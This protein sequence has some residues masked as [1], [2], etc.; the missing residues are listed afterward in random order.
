[1]GSVAVIVTEK[2]AEEIKKVGHCELRGKVSESATTQNRSDAFTRWFLPA[3][4]CGATKA[5][6]EDCH[7]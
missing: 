2:V 7:W 5:C 1:V 6:A 4:E 3:I